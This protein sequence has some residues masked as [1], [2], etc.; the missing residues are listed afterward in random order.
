MYISDPIGSDTTSFHITTENEE[1]DIFTEMTLYTKEQTSYKLTFDLKDYEKESNNEMYVSKENPIEEKEYKFIKT[2]KVYSY[3]DTKYL[4]YRYKKEYEEDYV[5][6]KEGYIKDETQYKTYYKV[7]HQDKIVLKENY[8]IKDPYYN[9]YDMIESSTIPKDQIQI[10]SS[11]DI[12]K[13][14]SYK[15]SFFYQDYCIDQYVMVDREEQMDSIVFTDRSNMKKATKVNIKKKKIPKKENS[16]LNLLSV[17]L[18]LS[19]ETFD[20]F[21]RI[22]IFFSEIYLYWNR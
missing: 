4:Y 14:G 22:G 7:R 20:K 19:K 2:Y 12:T 15:V 18:K 5:K 6:E 3:Q 1:L 8:I 16:K 11:I 9:L 17:L 21:C 10:K 13:N